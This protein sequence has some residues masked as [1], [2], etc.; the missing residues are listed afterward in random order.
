MRELQEDVHQPAEP[1]LP[2]RLEQGQRADHGQEAEEE[3]QKVREWLI[4]VL[5]LYRA[6]GP[7]PGRVAVRGSADEMFARR[8]EALAP[9]WAAQVR[10]WEAER[11]AVE[12]RM[13]ASAPRKELPR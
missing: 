2:H 10:Q 13:L 7:L 11:A 5:W 3:G 9:G 12:G 4:R 6:T 1:R 8:Q